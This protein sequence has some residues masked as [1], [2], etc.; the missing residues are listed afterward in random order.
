M[1]KMSID[2]FNQLKKV[3]QQTTAEND[4]VA[5]MALRKANSVIAAC[6]YTWED[7]FNR[8]IKVDVPLV[9]VSEGPSLKDTIRTAFNE[10]LSSDPKGSFADFISS[11]SEQYDS[12]GFLTQN[13]KDALFKAAQ[14]ARNKGTR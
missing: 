13:Q 5:L 8:L 12:K 11:L 6:G 2:K 10:V 7:I 14:K 3:M 1:G 4:N 9:P